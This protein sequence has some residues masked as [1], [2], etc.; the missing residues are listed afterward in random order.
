[1]TRTVTDSGE[2]EVVVLSD[3]PPTTDPSFAWSL[4][5]RRSVRTGSPDPALDPL[6]FDPRSM[7]RLDDGTWIVA[8]A[9]RR[10]LAIVPSDRDTVSLLFSRVGQGPGEL[11]GGYPVLWPAGNGSFWVADRGNWRVSR[12]DTTGALLREVPLPSGPGATSLSLIPRQI[13]NRL[14]S[15]RYTLPEGSDDAA[16]AHSV[17]AVDFGTGS[18]ETLVRLEQG[19]DPPGIMVLWNHRALWTVLEDGHLVTGHDDDMTFAMRTLTGELVREVRVDLQPRPV[20]EADRR[21]ILTELGRAPS[22]V[23]LSEFFPFTDIYLPFSD[24]V[25]AFRHTWVSH[26]RGDVVPEGTL[27]WRLISTGG[28]YLGAITFPSDFEPKWTDGEVLLGILR[29]SLGVAT[30]QEYALIPPSAI[31]AR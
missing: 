7:T 28:Y 21:R 13:T 20:D 8:D 2:P 29:D 30:M 17:V 3:V 18:Q 9:G 11:Y 5:L 22:S 24:S 4:V 15:Q 23:R 31:A 14:F 1:M 27:A 16:G 6:L 26:A 10:P 12:F 19:V 25:F